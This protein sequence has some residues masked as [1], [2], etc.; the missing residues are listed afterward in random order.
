MGQDIEVLNKIDLLTDSQINKIQKKKDVIQIPM[1]ALTGEGR[2][3]LLE[4]IDNVLSANFENVEIQIPI[5]DGKFLAWVYANTT[6]IDVRNT[7]K[8][9]LI[10]ARISPENF[11]ILQ[12]KNNLYKKMAGN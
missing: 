2:E 3:L 4:E 10:K 1:S 11:S 9:V 12:H 8:Y 6:I 7:N 5:E